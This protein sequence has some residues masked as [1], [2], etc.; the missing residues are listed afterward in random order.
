MSFDLFYQPCH[1]GTE[2][3]ERKDAVTGEVQTNLPVKPLSA[4]DLKSVQSLLA[5]DARET[6]EFGA[7]VVE[8]ADG[9]LAEI[10][11]GELTTG[12]MAV[13]EGQPVIYSVGKDGQDDG[14]RK[15]SKFDSQLGD[16]IYRLRP[17]DD[18]R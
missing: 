15:D 9:G 1:F 12:L 7:F 8:A 13:V 18:P 6:D 11:C 5:K 16:L 3:V 17:V 2:P 10:I 14:A 4:H